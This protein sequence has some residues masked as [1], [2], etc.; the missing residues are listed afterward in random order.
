MEQ[1]QKKRKEKKIYACMRGLITSSGSEDG[2]RSIFT[3][4]RL[5][6]CR[7]S[8][9]SVKKLDQNPTLVTQGHDLLTFLTIVAHCP[10]L[11][12]LGVYV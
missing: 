7:S 1:E 9:S 5:L 11:H 10:T 6:I 2:I 8:N 12:T 3:C 4:E